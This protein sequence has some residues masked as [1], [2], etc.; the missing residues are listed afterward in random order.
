MR[1]PASEKLGIIRIVEQ[2]HLPTKI[3]LDKLGV[4]AGPSTAGMTAIWKEGLKRWRISHQARAVSGTAFPTPSMPRSSI[5]R[6]NSP[7]CHR[8]NWRYG[9]PMSDVTSCRKPR[10]TG[11]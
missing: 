11:C 3:T 10:F 8:V 6:W 4:A 2:S 7:S 5:W 9:L 1:Y